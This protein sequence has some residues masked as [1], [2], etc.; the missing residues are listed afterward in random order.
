VHDLLRQHLVLEE[1]SYEPVDVNAETRK[2]SSE[3][4]VSN[5]ESRRG[6]LDVAKGPAAN[7]EECFLPVSL[8]HGLRSNLGNSLDR[9]PKN[10]SF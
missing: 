4:K 7:L 9:L 5:L 2:E 6:G 10:C 3:W 1:L 8:R